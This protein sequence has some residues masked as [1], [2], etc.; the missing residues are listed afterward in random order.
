[1][2]ISAAHSINGEI[3]IPGD[4]SISHRGAII[5]SITHET[6]A[7]KNFLFS[8]DCLNTLAVLGRLGVKTDRKSVV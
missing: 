6:V 1:M 5:S 3:K 4:K 2:E 7:I 8:E